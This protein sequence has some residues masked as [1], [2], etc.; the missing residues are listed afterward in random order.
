MYFQPLQRFLRISSVIA[1]WLLPQ[2][3]P[4]ECVRWKP[5][6]RPGN[7]APDLDGPGS[8]GELQDTVTLDCLKYVGSIQAEKG[9]EFV[10]I[11]DERGKIYRLHRGSYMGENTGIIKKIDA[12][13]IYISQ[14][15]S[16]NGQWEEVIVKFPKYPRTQ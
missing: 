5:E 16:R 13:A 7:V 9:N 2:W 4:A 6:P 3:A 14:L 10:F 8:F 1:I 11:Q 15:V 12:G